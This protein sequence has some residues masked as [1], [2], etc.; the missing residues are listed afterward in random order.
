MQAGQPRLNPLNFTT[1]KFLLQHAQYDVTKAKIYEEY[2]DSVIKKYMLYDTTGKLDQF[3]K[4]LSEKGKGKDQ[5]SLK[6]RLDAIEANDKETKKLLTTEL[7]LNEIKIPEL[8]EDYFLVNRKGTIKETRKVRRL[9][10]KEQ[11]EITRKKRKKE[12]FYNYSFTEKDKFSADNIKKYLTDPARAGEIKTVAI[13]N[14]PAGSDASLKVKSTA[15][16]DRSAFQETTDTI[17]GL[18]VKLAELG[19]KLS[20]YGNILPTDFIKTSNATIDWP[21]GAPSQAVVEYFLFGEPAEDTSV[22]LP[23]ISLE[24][25]IESLLIVEN[26]FD[27]E[28]FATATSAAFLTDKSLTDFPLATTNFNKNLPAH[29]VFI[30]EFIAAYK[31]ELKVQQAKYFDI[32]R[33][34]SLHLSFM[35]PAFANSSLPPGELETD[36]KDE[37]AKYYSKILTTDASEEPVK[38]ELQ[39]IGLKGKDSTHTVAKFS[40]KVG[41]NYRFQFGA[42]IAYTLRDF[43]QSKAKEENGNVVIENNAQHYRLVVGVHVHFGKGLFLQDNRFMGRFKERSSVYFGVGMPKPLENIYLG[44]A[45]DILPGLKLTAG[46]HIYRNDEYKIQNNTIIEQRMKYK[47]AGP[48]IALQIDPAGLLKALDVI[49]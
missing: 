48:F 43:I 44:Y 36:T 23:A 37:T 3:K 39:I 38:N 6:E 17:L 30:D 14:I 46:G 2:I 34:D 10:S 8:K 47:G 5:F 13:H 1:E 28:V 20:P 35:Y 16:T 33:T 40:Y 19:V 11:K 32:L 26:I 29:K 27:R 21:A 7:V 49:N 42:G 24:K 15:I 4:I 12:F 25:T 41:K 31:E 9:F 22:I 45:Y 18:A